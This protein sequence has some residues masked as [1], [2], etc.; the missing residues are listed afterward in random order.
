MFKHV[1][2]VFLLVMN[3]GEYGI[4]SSS[5]A[6]NKNNLRIRGWMLNTCMREQA[7]RWSTFANLPSK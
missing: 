6:M 5:N 7:H 3:T 2:Q 1:L 4:C